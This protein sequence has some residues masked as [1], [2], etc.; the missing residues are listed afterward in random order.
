M[1]HGEIIYSGPTKE[2]FESDELVEKYSLVLPQLLELKSQLQKKG[3]SLKKHYDDLEA[4]IKDAA[5]EV[6]R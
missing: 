1:D 3:F 4:L 2:L 6:K 5:K